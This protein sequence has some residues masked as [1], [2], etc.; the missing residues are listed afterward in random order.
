MEKYKIEMVKIKQQILPMELFGLT[1]MYVYAGQTQNEY[2]A[3][4]SGPA[5]FA[6]KDVP[7]K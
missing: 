1:T 4:Y 2:Q 7:I 6:T 5:I 3:T